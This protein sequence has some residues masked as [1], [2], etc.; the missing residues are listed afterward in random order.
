MP[1]DCN[2]SALNLNLARAIRAVDSRFHEWKASSTAGG[3]GSLFEGEGPES[4][5]GQIRH[6]QASPIAGLHAEPVGSKERR[7]AAP[8]R[9]AVGSIRSKNGVPAGLR[10]RGGAWN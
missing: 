8:A 1:G 6:A 2:N 9:F 4:S 7:L 3:E 5:L 10:H